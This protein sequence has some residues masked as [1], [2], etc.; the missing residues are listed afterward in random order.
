MADL[1]SVTPRTDPLLIEGITLR[2]H[3]L[4]LFDKKKILKI[5]LK[6]QDGRE[7]P[8]T[9]VWI[10]DIPVSCDGAGIE[11]ALVKLGCVLHSFLIFERIR[12]KVG[13]LTRFL[14]GRRFIF[15]DVP[16]KTS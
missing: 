16:P 7:T 5:I 10:P 8:S 15:I 3:A 4:T 1:P 6:E 9:K 2:G 12:N 13:T 14:T 11:S